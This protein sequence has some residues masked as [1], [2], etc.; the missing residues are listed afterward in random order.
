MHEVALTGALLAIVEEY[1]QREKFGRVNSLR[2]SLGRLSCLDPEAL[3]F[4]FA[5]QA[6]GTVAEGAR[7]EFAIQPAVL[8]CVACGKDSV[9]EGPFETCCPHCGS[10]DVLLTGGTQDLKLLELDVD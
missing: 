8:A 2:L 4:T 1:A 5:V 6:R 7:L 10:C 3:E 9:C